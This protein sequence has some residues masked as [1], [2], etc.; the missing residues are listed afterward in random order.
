MQ[1]QHQADGEIAVHQPLRRIDAKHRRHDAVGGAGADVDVL[2][3]GL[4]EQRQRPGRHDVGEHEH[5]GYELF[6]FDVRARDQ[7]GHGAAK[8]NGDKRGG[9]R[10]G[11]GVEER[12]VELNPAV[13]Q[14]Y[15]RVAAIV[16]GKQQ[17]FKVIQ[18]IIAG[19]KPQRFHRAR[20]A[21]RVYRDRFQQ[22]GQQRIKRKQA[23]RHQEDQQD[24]VG[25]LGKIR[26]Q[27]AHQPAR[28]KFSGAFHVGHCPPFG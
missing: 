4:P 7:E 21:P 15:A 1:A 26:P 3:E 5:G 22:H 9:Q 17:L 12:A 2:P 24:H 18:R 27:P 14:L 20:L 19:R 25:G 11:Q 8:Q 16:E 13:G 6:I 10:H 23:Q 28:L